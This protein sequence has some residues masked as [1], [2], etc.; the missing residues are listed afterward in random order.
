MKEQIKRQ[1]K[2]RGG[3][4]HRDIE[5]RREKPT[6]QPTFSGEARR[7]KFLARSEGTIILG[8]VDTLLCLLYSTVQ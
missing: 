3:K 6:C 2:R 8:E 1:R 5:N 4:K 7:L